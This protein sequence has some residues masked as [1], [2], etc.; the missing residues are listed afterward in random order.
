MNEIAHTWNTYPTP[1]PYRII[2]AMDLYDGHDM[3]LCTK[4]YAC[5][6]RD[7]IICYRCLVMEYLDKY[8]KTSD[9]GINH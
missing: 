3:M 6:G 1:T 4:P 2:C 9:E 7:I 5:R 8:D